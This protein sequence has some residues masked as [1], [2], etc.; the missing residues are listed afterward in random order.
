MDLIKI[1]DGDSDKEIQ[2]K[3]PIFLDDKISIIK[4]KIFSVNKLLSPSF[5]RLEAEGF[6]LDKDLYL[7][8]YGIKGRIIKVFNILS[9]KLD[10]TYTEIKKLWTDLSKEEYDAII[11]HRFLKTEG[12]EGEKYVEFINKFEGERKKLDFKKDMNINFMHQPTL[13][14]RNKKGELDINIKSIV[15][16]IELLTE[17]NWDKVFKHIEL[18]SDVPVVMFKKNLRDTPEVKLYKGARN[19]NLKEQLFVSGELKSGKGMTCFVRNESNYI[20][21]NMIGKKIR[22]K[23]EPSKM[24]NCGIR[25]KGLF[26]RI[27]KIEKM[28]IINEVIDSVTSE[29]I[30]N[31]NFE[32]ISFQLKDYSLFFKF[33]RI[34]EAETET[35]NLKYIRS[36]PEISV[37]IKE[38][39]NRRKLVIIA[40]TELQTRIIADLL[41]GLIE[42]ILGEVVIDSV[43]GKANV[44]KLK[45][46]GAKVNAVSCQKNRQPVISLTE[47]PLKSKNAK[48]PDGYELNYK[49][50]RYI[51][52]NEDFI[53]PGF[54]IKEVPCCFTSS[55]QNK[56]VYQ[57][58]MTPDAVQI[59]VSPSNL[60]IEIEGEA[61]IALKTNDNKYVYMSN[62]GELVP[63]SDSSI[64][65]KIKGMEKKGNVFM[66]SVPLTKLKTNPQ[67]SNCKNS[68]VDIV[69]RKCGSNKRFPH[70]GYTPSGDPCCFNKPREVLIDMIGDTEV[71]QHIITTDKILNDNRLG[72]LP[73]VVEAMLSDKFFRLGVIQ[74]NKAFLNCIIKVMESN[75]PVNR[76]IEELQNKIS[77]GS[78]NRLSGVNTIFE[79]A[80]AYKEYLETKWL[81]HKMVIELISKHYKINVLVLNKAKDTISCQMFPFNKSHKYAVILKQDRF[82]EPLV[83]MDKRLFTKGEIKNILDLYKFSCKVIKPDNYPLELKKVYKKLGGDIK[84]VVNEAGYVNF[85]IFKGGLIPV[86]ASKPLE[87]IKELSGISGIKVIDV[88][89]QIKILN[90]LSESKLQVKSQILGDKGNVVGIIVESGLIV[91]VKG[92]KVDNLEITN[93]TYYSDIDEILQMNDSQVDD[94]VRNVMRRLVSDEYYER[95]RFIVSEYLKDNQRYRNDIK[96]IKKS[97]GDRLHK[98]KLISEII[99]SILLKLISKKSRQNVEIDNKRRSCNKIESEKDCD[100]YCIWDE[101]CRLMSLNHISSSK[102]LD[103]LGLFITQDILKNNEILDTKVNEEIIGSDNFIRRKGEIVFVDPDQLKVWF[104]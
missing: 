66:K 101:G 61:Y 46:K 14:N 79:N 6:K 62:K 3:Y 68:P 85:V 44:K 29:L 34:G 86:A 18:S 75:E 47:T 55:Q 94:R 88:K 25:L 56:P 15:Y 48:K 32:E 36:N 74:N 93:M 45:E 41:G 42:Q 50:N 28:N 104:D 40:K 4:Q 31:K 82:Y 67:K 84:Q 2:V 96:E 69:L 37:S 8:E 100:N 71:V 90:G 23:C 63:I 54:T 38:F 98:V 59:K 10:S 27:N 17:L 53:Y 57:R 97:D 26:T 35:L 73:K 78:L 87:N 51:C 39:Q 83:K 103:Q 43:R 76:S 19:Q 20:Q 102:V 22:V 5:V 11:L 80:D 65:E 9:N 58:L 77:D 13:Y 81:D 91:P 30:I 52:Q 64:I 33:A 24:E 1:F 89:E 72:V 70:F 92:S 99:G 60:P 12:G 16:N 7:Y 95:T 49:G 21:V